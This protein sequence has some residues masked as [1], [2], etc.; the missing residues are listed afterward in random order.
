MDWQK[1][2]FGREE[3]EKELGLTA[4][5]ST[6]SEGSSTGVK[7]NDL[8][9]EGYLSQ[10]D[11]KRLLGNSKLKQVFVDAGGSADSWET[12]NDVDA[13][14][15]YLTKPEEDEPEAKPDIKIKEITKPDS[16]R[17]A[18]AKERVQEYESEMWSGKHAESMF[19][20]SVDPKGF[21]EKYKTNFAKNHQ[22]ANKSFKTPPSLRQKES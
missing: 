6:Y 9:G 21:L 11:Y 16:E 19:A 18:T 2:S 5:D 12:I 20:P 22:T 17:L 3:L 15:D 10:D 4:G 14:I 8:L 1:G 7:S 13:A